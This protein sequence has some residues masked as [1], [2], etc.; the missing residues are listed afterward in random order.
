MNEAKGM[1]GLDSA[2]YVIFCA[3]DGSRGASRKERN[4]SSCF[5]GQPGAILHGSEIREE[6]QYCWG[7]AIA[8]PCFHVPAVNVVVDPW[9]SSALPMAP[10]EKDD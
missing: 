1:V 10:S 3:A 9:K 7:M 6:L 5:G 8:S 4:C 2:R